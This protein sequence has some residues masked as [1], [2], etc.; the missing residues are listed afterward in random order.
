MKSQKKYQWRD[1]TSSQAAE[2]SE[3]TLDARIRQRA[4][5]LYEERNRETGHELDDWLRAESEVK[6]TSLRAS[7]V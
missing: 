7:A 1:A 6:G 4:Y 2:T 3:L 5:E